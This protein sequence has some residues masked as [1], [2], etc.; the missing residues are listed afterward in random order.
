MTSLKFNYTYPDISS[1][2]IAINPDTII[3]KNVIISVMTYD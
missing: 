3:V 1:N 2:A